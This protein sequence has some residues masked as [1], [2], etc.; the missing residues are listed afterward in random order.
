MFKVVDN[1]SILHL[2]RS[3][4]I[5][6]GGIWQCGL[7][8]NGSYLAMIHSSPQREKRDKDRHIKERVDQYRLERHAVYCRTDLYYGF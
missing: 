1:K 5:L 8:A 6:I 2:C 7:I 4:N 3:A